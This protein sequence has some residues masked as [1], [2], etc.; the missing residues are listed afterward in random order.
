MISKRSTTPSN[1]QPAHIL[2]SRNVKHILRH[3]RE[4]FL[5]KQALVLWC[6]WWWW[7]W[8]ILNLFHSF[9]FD[10]ITKYS[11]FKDVKEQGKEKINPIKFLF[12]FIPSN[13]H[14]A[15]LWLYLKE[16][17]KNVYVH[18]LSR[19]WWWWWR[20]KDIEWKRR[21]VF[22][23]SMN[24]YHHH[25]CYF[26]FEGAKMKRQMCTINTHKILLMSF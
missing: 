16:E 10:S 21:M 22:V 12:P 2:Y 24:L 13:T 17:K 20:E 26:I 15:F 9:I 3:Y 19:M 25:L 11:H 18:S 23:L 7:F 6:R 8:G 14:W 1:G 5:K 4:C